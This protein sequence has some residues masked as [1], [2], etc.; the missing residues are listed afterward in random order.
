M[1]PGKRSLPTASMLAAALLL[2]AAPAAPQATGTVTGTV[3]DSQTGRALS[4]VQVFVPGTSVATM[5]R[6]QGRFDL[7]NVPAGETVIRAEMI[8]YAPREQ[9]VSVS[10]GETLTV[11]F[12]L[13]A[14]AI[15]LR[16]LVVTGT[17]G[18]MER[19]AMGNVV[20]S[21]N[22]AELTERMHMTTIGDLLQHRVP[23]MAVYSPAGTHGIAP[24]IQLRGLTSV[25][26]PSDPVIYIDGV[27]VDGSHDRDGVWLGGQ[28]TSRMQDISPH[29]IERIEVVKGAAAAT[30][31][32][33]Q[34][35][36][37]VIQIFTKRGAAGE[38]QWT[39]EV[40]GGFERM[41]TDTFP[42]RLFTQFQ[43]P[44]GFQ[45]QDPIQEV[46]NGYH[47]RYNLSV[48]GGTDNLRYYLAGGLRRGEA[49]I[50]PE[51]NWERHYSTRANIDALVSQNMTIT[52][53]TSVSFS[54]AR[55][56]RGENAW[57]SI[58]QSFAAGIPYTATEQRPYG[59]PG[60]NI[61]AHATMEHMQGT[62]R[63]TSGITVDHSPMDWLRHRA[64]LGMDWYT[65]ETTTYFPFGYTGMFYPQGN[66]LNHTRQFRDI[67]VDYR[68]SI[69][70]TLSPSVGLQFSA[71]SQ[72]N[73]TDIVRV[74][75]FGDQFPGPGLETVAA[76]ANTSA[77]EWITRE[78]NAGVFVDQ[79]LEV[80]DRLFLG[81]GVRLDGNSAFGD[82]FRYQAYPKA[83][84]AYNISDEDFWPTH[85]VPTMKLRTAYGAAGRA[86]AQF[87]A[88]RTYGPISGKMG[89]PAV[90]PANIGDPDLG[91]ET[92]YEFEIGFD[93]GLWD[94][95]VGMEFTVWRHRTVDALMNVNFPPSQGFLQSQ[96]V[97]LGEVRN[98]G[99]ELMLN[100]LLMRRTGF[101]WS[102]DVQ[103]SHQT[104]ELTDMGGLPPRNLRTTRLNEGFPVNGIWSYEVE[105]DP[106]TRSHMWSDTMVYVGPA[107]PVWSGGL[108]SNV[109]WRDFTLSGTA[110]F[111][112]GHHR[113]SFQHWWDTYTGTG[114]M[115]LELVERPHGGSTPAADSLW[116]YTVAGGY[117]IFNYR[118]DFVRIRELSVGYDIPSQW[119]Q[120]LGADRASVR[121]SARNL[122]HWSKFPGMDPEVGYYGAEHVGRGMDW[123]STPLPRHFMFTLRTTF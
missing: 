26:L 50:R 53:N 119:V 37:G 97:N 61:E 65:E 29:D 95:R 15:G 85:L 98:E 86:P 118:G 123:N 103:V 78:V 114:D 45:A 60:G 2:W 94:D 46:G 7:R 14:Q 30:L 62:R 70:R 6:A 84:L 20:A 90:T 72:A 120:A 3:V 47:Q 32:G 17:A 83:S 77:G 116:D 121:F 104:S 79:T 25:S 102:M 93:A 27:R 66:K 74:E 56:P 19:R 87:A 22:A 54:D 91:P 89:M 40:S 106:A 4:G 33:T 41:A 10:A 13:S 43:G 88:D 11:D 24:V 112:A 67:T 49:S 63:A 73:F 38:P 12:Q 80:W 82:E 64:T 57:E 8:G 115:Y 58:Y 101:E 48:G 1:L 55:I 5:S 81:A 23:G 99:V 111:A 52:A 92:S 109:R 51:T 113:V 16:E 18:E 96:F 108:S 110:G 59:E 105:W 36:N 34:G 21:V 122:W 42:G 76:A 68:A 75:A 28:H 71:G 35:S 100:T 69:S 117:N 31:Y 44:D 107:D 9:T 39:L